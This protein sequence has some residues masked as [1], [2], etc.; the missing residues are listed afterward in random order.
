MKKV[1][2]A[3]GAL[4]IGVLLLPDTASAQRR[5][6]GGMPRSIAGGGAFRGPGLAVRPGFI[7]SGY[8]A[9]LGGYGYRGLGYSGR[10]LAYGGYRPVYRGI[11][12][13]GRRWAYGG[14]GGYRPFYRGYRRSYGYGGALA[15]GLIGGLALGSSLGYYGA[16][17]DVGYSYADP[18]YAYPSDGNVVYEAYPPGLTQPCYGGRGCRADGYPDARFYGGY[19]GR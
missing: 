8:R 16:P 13:S 19:Y 2:V 1:L 14:Y 7:G 18:G 12:Y 4:A 15:A 9:G 17:Y 6:W 10:R 3:T 11:G 5:G